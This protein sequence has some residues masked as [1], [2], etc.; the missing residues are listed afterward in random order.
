MCD[1][2]GGS[3]SRRHSN[4]ETMFSSHPTTADVLVSDAEMTF[5]QPQPKKY[6]TILVRYQTAPNIVCVC[7]VSSDA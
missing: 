3:L 6:H 2:G 5:C 7:M 4:V 1:V